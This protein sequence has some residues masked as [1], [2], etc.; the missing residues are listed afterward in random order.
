MPI[1][2]Y[3]KL[4]FNFGLMVDHVRRNVEAYD[5]LPE[6]EKEEISKVNDS[7]NQAIKSRLSDESTQ[8]IRNSF[9]KELNKHSKGEIDAET[10][11]DIFIRMLS[12][13]AEYA[14]ITHVNTRQEQERRRELANSLSLA[15]SKV[16]DTAVQ[17]DD[18]ALGHLLASGFEQIAKDFTKETI[19]PEMENNAFSF[20]LLA[21]QLRNQYFP[22]MKSFCAGMY[23]AV[24]T[25]PRISPDSST[26]Q[27]VIAASLEEYLGRLGIPT[28]TTETGLA[29]KSLHTVM[30]MAG[31]EISKAGYWLEKAKKSP[32]SWT[33]FADRL[34]KQGG[35]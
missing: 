33:A 10:E 13:W 11:A 5:A 17:L 21:D 1:N 29:G 9:I 14:V 3:E 8:D 12:N 22:Q 18:A 4:I 16:L 34:N 35:S 6:N 25:L 7:I 19:P 32:N 24:N 2:D 26:P 23:V 27:F 31:I 20:L 15:F 30:A 28:T